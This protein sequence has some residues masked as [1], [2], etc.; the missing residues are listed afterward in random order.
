MSDESIRTERI[1][2]PAGVVALELSAGELD[3]AAEI[4]VECQQ[5]SN[6]HPESLLTSDE[7]L[8]VQRAVANTLR[9]LRTMI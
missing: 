4:L 8:Q 9:R 1:L 7:F 6:Y 2:L 3:A 5:R